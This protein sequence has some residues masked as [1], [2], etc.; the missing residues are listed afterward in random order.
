M[1]KKLQIFQIL[2]PE[3]LA[4]HGLLHADS[5]GPATDPQSEFHNGLARK[6]EGNDQCHQGEAR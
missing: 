2:S 3:H 6:A 1:Q 4:S 5:L